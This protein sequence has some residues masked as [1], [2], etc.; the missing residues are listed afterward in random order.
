MKA[1]TLDRGLKMP[2]YEETP[3]A[4]KKHK[5]KGLKGRLFSKGGS[6]APAIAFLMYN[7]FIMNYY[8]F[9]IIVFII[10]K[11]NCIIQAFPGYL[12]V[13]IYSCYL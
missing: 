8:N 1:L 9:F 2:T 11:I 3:D 12:R 6:N 5:R 4:I 13:G 7:Y 10:S